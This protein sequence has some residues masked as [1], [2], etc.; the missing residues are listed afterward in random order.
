MD[1]IIVRVLTA[2][3]E[4]GI[5][6]VRAMPDGIMPRL[7]GPRAA[8]CFERVKRSSPGLYEYLGTE[9]T[10]DRGEVERYGR[11]ISAVLLIR[12]CAPDGQAVSPRVCRA[13]EGGIRGVTIGEITA[14]A[15]VF[16][17][18]ADV[19]VTEVRAELA[20]YLIAESTD[21]SVQFLDFRLE[22]EVK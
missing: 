12:V 1:E 5:P 18:V 16:D 8:V 19:F 10:A 21:D 14:S 17:P 7:K 15:A 9:E 13:L 4:A 2:L 6:A 20:A 11:R 22:G 3:E